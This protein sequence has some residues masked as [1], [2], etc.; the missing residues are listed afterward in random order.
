MIAKTC[1]FFLRGRHPAS[2]RYSGL[3]TISSWQVFIQPIH[4]VTRIAIVET[5]N[6][7]CHET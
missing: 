2:W 7:V 5:V 4:E 1:T 3:L 6:A